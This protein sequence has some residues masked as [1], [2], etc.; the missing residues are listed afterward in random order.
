MSEETK[1]SLVT[2]QLR[3]SHAGYDVVVTHHVP[4]GEFRQALLSLLKDLSEAGIAPA[5]PEDEG[6]GRKEKAGPIPQETD[7]PYHALAREF[8]VGADQV[9]RIVGIKGDSV[10]LYKASQFKIADAVC[11]ICFAYEKALG[12]SSM[13]YDVLTRLLETSQIKM[14]TPTSVMCFNMIND[15]Y[16]QK[17]A[18][19]EA[20][21]VVLESKG[22]RKAREFV[23]QLLA[24]SYRAKEAR[25]RAK[26]KPAK[27]AK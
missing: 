15:G 21:N 27:K 19:D 9:R 25:A 22:E 16:F 23:Q 7:D 12:H 24:G 8:D 11:L 5:R 20:R 6:E 4:R 13:S 3:G 17:R 1:S 18:Y 10:Q 14:K 26:A 2:V